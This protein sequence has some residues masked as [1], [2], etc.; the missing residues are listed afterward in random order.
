MFVCFRDKIKDQRYFY[1]SLLHN[2]GLNKRKFER[3][4]ER[5][6]ETTL[7]ALLMIDILFIAL[8]RILLTV[9]FAYLMTNWMSF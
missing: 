7:S 4:R 3:E 8:F 5:E 9:Y 2:L 6:K 1:R